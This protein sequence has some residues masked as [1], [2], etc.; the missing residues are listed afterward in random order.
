MTFKIGGFLVGSRHGCVSTF[1]YVV[2]PCVCRGLE[3]GRSPIQRDLPK[4]L[5]RFTVSE[6]NSESK[7]ARGPIRDSYNSNGGVA[8]FYHQSQCLIRKSHP[9]V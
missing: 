7:P 4:C 1:F 2:L 5:N 6:L 9:S 3:M 8:S